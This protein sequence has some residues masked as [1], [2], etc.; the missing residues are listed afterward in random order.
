LAE[1]VPVSLV[2]AGDVSH[3]VFGAQVWVTITA[4]TQSKSAVGQSATLVQTT[5]LG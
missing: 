5:G 2:C 3:L 1:Q 4:F